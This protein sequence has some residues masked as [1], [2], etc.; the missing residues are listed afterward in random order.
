[1][2]SAEPLIRDRLKSVPGVLAVH[3]M[4]DPRTVV[5]MPTKFPAL[6]VVHDGFEI[7]QIMGQTQAAKVSPRWLVIVAVKN[8]ADIRDGHPARD[9][10]TDIATHVIATLM[11]WQPSPAY[12][13]LQPINPPLKPIYNDGLLLYP[14]AFKAPQII[15]RLPD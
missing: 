13:P 2:L 11:G 8:V 10:S 12:Q 6:F 7:D 9:D 4:V 14:L 15:N 3:G 1:M 5:N